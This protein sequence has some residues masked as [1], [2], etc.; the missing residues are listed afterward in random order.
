M[1]KFSDLFST[2]FQEGN[3]TLVMIDYFMLILTMF[4]LLE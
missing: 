1:Y 4:M 2:N 3:L